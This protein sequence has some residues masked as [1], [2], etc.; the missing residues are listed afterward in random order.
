MALVVAG[1]LAAPSLG[2]VNVK[3][4]ADDTYMIIGS[5]T[6]IRIWAQ[7]TQAGIFSLAGNITPI[8][9]NS[10]SAVPGSFCWTAAFTPWVLFFPINGPAGVRGGWS[11]FG[12]QQTDWG[13]P[14]ASCGKADYV[15]VA[16]YTVQC[17]SMGMTTLAFSAANVSGYKPLECDKTGV[18]GTLLPVQAGEVPEPVSLALL[19]VGVLAGI[20]R[21]VP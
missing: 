20:W 6:T 2:V 12:S 16:N 3:L 5:S 14:N 15:E 11:N 9:G 8:S 7:G 1:L 19:A 13:T 4:T 10:L 18:L 17:V 21:R